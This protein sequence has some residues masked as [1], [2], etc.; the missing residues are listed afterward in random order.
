MGNTKPVLITGGAGF[1]GSHL[2]DL[3]QEKGIKYLILDNLSTG[4]VEN[5]PEAINSNSFVCGDVNDHKLLSELI[6]NSSMVIHLASTVGVKN[7]ISNPLETIDTNVNS[8]KF[9]AGICTAK[10]I[11]LIFFSSSLVY[12]SYR[13]NNCVFSEDDQVHSLGFH[14]VSM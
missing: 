9:I 6:T 3:L 13:G 7:V 4:M 14:P 12:S 2:V 10:K 5:I 1:I 11:P 8:L